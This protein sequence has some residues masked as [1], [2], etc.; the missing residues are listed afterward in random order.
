MRLVIV[1]SPY[2]GDVARNIDYAR[3]A[4]RDCF[5]RGEAPYASH[6]LFT[7]PGILDDGHPHERAQG[8]EAGLLWGRHAKATVVYMDFGLSPGMRQ[9]MERAHAE[10]RPVFMRTLGGVWSKAPYS[11]LQVAPPPGLGLNGEKQ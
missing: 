8:I 5:E 1:E 4:L 9:G 11:E 6:L 2:A 10:K 7:Q 3:A